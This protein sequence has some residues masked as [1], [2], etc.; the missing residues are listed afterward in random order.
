MVIASRDPARSL[1]DTMHGGG[2][3]AKKRASIEE[4]VEHFESLPRAAGT[5]DERVAATARYFKVKPEAVKRHLKFWWPGKKFLKEFGVGNGRI[6]W[7]RPTGELLEA[8]NR[9]GSVS[10]A[11]KSLGTTPITLTKAI[12]RHGIV[13]RW[14]EGESGAR[15]DD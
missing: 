5:P 15:G 6:K 11:A 14:M 13:Q 3:M 10:A 7:D 12:E 1:T 9:Y 4:I 8:L 2:A